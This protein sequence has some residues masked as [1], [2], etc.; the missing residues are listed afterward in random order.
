MDLFLQV[1]KNEDRSE[2][3]RIKDTGKILEPTTEAQLAASR[4]WQ[5][6]VKHCMLTIREEKIL[7][8][9]FAIVDLETEECILA[10]AEHP[11]STGVE[12][13]IRDLDLLLFYTRQA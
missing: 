8:K 9:I 1:P 2:S 3:V 12:M 13:V 10:L 7:K 6:C 5:Q 4:R 11:F